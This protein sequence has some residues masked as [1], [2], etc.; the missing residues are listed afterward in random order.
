MANGN[1]CYQTS[2]YHRRHPKLL[3]H[4]V[5]DVYMLNADQIA[6]KKGAGVPGLK[7]LA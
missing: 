3:Y 7:T 1:D 4:G 2:C 5:Q 6:N